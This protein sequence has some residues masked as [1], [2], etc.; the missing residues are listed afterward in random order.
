M[1]KLLFIFIVLFSS[2]FYS[3]KNEPA[4]WIIISVVENE[5]AVFHSS[6]QTDGTI[7]TWVDTSQNKELIFNLSLLPNSSDYIDIIKVYSTNP[8]VAYIN[9]IDLDTRTISVKTINKGEAKIIVK[10]K[11]FSSCSSPIITVR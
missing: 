7:K 6:Y 5:D 2:I 9:Y 10:T 11:S 3:C 4:K 8:D 1:K